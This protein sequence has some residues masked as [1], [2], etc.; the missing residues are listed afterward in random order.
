M[1]W[2]LTLTSLDAAYNIRIDCTDSQSGSRQSRWEVI[3]TK[4]HTWEKAIIE[5]EMNQRLSAPLQWGQLTLF[6]T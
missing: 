5:K 6:Y 2:L 4:Y 1:D 3:L